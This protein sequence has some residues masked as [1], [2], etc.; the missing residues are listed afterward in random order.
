MGLEIQNLHKTFGKTR[1]LD[2]MTFTPRDGE[3]YGFVGSN[4]AGKTTT[5]RIILGVLNADSGTVT[6]DGKPITSTMKFGYMPEERGLYPKM[7]VGQQLVYL[8][9]LHGL[10]RTD[11]KAAME[12][13][14]DRLG[15]AGRRADQVQALS[16][17]NQQRV[18]LAAALI[19]NP[20]VMILDEPF[21][22]LDPLAVT[23]M[24]EVLK[25][26]VAEGAT[27]VFS[28][29]QLDLVERL[30]DRVGICSLGKI[31]SE[32]SIADLRHSHTGVIEITGPD[33][34]TLATE[35]GNAGYRVE[36][37]E[38][39]VLVNL[40]KGADDQ[41]ILRAALRIGPVH[42]FTPHY[43]HLTELFQDVVQQPVPEPESPAPK[44][45]LSQLFSR[46]K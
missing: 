33:L 23:A 19:H 45:G 40:P 7:P 34:P 18:Q 21:S 36:M 46:K 2:G 8:A 43:P 35:L 29:H 31:V 25:E 41:E 1:A 28:S 14:T 38:D 44:R 11:A 42:S 39:T 12:Y 10:S 37:N 5:M 22:G 3:L 24:S 20:Q 30:C 15:V 13:W 4:G 17:G 6:Q 27:V 9:R 32:G 26:K 16:L